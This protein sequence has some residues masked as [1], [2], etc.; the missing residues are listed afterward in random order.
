MDNICRIHVRQLSGVIKTHVISLGAGD[1]IFHIEWPKS[2]A[3]HP[4]NGA[5]GEKPRWT[6]DAAVALAMQLNPAPQLPLSPPRSLSPPPSPDRKR[7]RLD[8]PP[9]AIA[10]DADLPS[11]IPKSGTHPEVTN[12]HQPAAVAPAESGTAAPLPIYE[13]TP[14]PGS[15]RSLRNA[16]TT[17][18][19]NE[20][21]YDPANP[22]MAI[23][24][25]RP[26]KVA[27]S[28]FELK[29]YNNV[30]MP[31]VTDQMSQAL[32]FWLAQRMI[33]AQLTKGKRPNV[34]LYYDYF[35][36]SQSSILT[37][38]AHER[39]EDYRYLSPD[40][41]QGNFQA[42]V[43]IYGSKKCRQREQAKKWRP[44]QL[45]GNQWRSNVFGAEGQQ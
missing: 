15:N 35:D 8:S 31:R 28:A 41:H 37:V 33:R 29:M 26:L 23:G 7:R 11:N 19:P 6:L 12:Q 32:R 3:G 5:A 45:S 42:L 22:S 13:P 17:V 39:A 24:S 44:A 36:I 18:R 27:T 38:G 30:R 34:Q 9:A 16:A 21:A 2:T 20:L 14:I 43:D 25:S 4:V 10:E 40:E 1:E